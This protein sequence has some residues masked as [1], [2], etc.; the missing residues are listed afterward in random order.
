MRE[1]L[2]NE[3]S[4]CGRQDDLVAFLYGELSEVETRTFKQHVDV[5]ASC[6]AELAAFSE[7]RESVVNWRNESLGGFLSPAPVTFETEE[8]TDR[9]SVGAL[10]AFREFFSLSP[11]WLKGAVAFAS[12][13]F[14]LFAGLAIAR[15]RETPPGAV[16]VAPAGNPSPQPSQQ[17]VNAL[18]E[19]R[20]QDELKRIN[21]S[22]TPETDSLLTA[23]SPSPKN[24]VKRRTNHSELAGN[25][26]EQKARRPLSKTEREQLAVDLRLVTA[27]SDSELELLDDAI[28]Q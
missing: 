16:A 28:N 25:R 21:D 24:S 17:E 22:R 2:L 11:L 26:I 12:L 3:V 1:E 27:K 15:L 23:T 18:V 10:A 20:V 14:C 7:V 6:N 8:R 9:R 19:K 5:C 13:L 4:K